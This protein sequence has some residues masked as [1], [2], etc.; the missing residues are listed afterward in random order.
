MRTK[1]G[2]LIL[3]VAAVAV[4]GTSVVLAHGS[5]STAFSGRELSTGTPL[6]DGTRV[7]VVFAGWTHAGNGTTWEGSP[8]SDGGGWATSVRYKGEQGLGGSGVNI[9]GGV[10]TWKQ[11][12]GKRH[13]ARVIGG[14]VQW[15]ADLGSVV[16]AEVNPKGCGNGVATFT[17]LLSRGF[18]L[19]YAGEI[20]GCLDDTH[21][22]LPGQP[23]VAPEDVV[24][25]PKIS[26]SLVLPH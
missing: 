11:S 4:I 16:P 14:R 17:V 10:W 25:P 5:G 8:N 18:T 1:I 22:G 15:P 24:F 20:L 9:T 12:D 7:G 2:G 23:P 19:A 13:T 3:A 6:D 26:G 21:T